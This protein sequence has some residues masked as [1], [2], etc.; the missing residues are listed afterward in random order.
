LQT[1]RSFLR[2]D[3][4]RWRDSARTGLRE[5]ASSAAVSR[6]RLGVDG[7]E[8]VGELKAKRRLRVGVVG[9]AGV[10]AWE[11]T[12]EVEREGETGVTSVWRIELKSW[13]A[14]SGELLGDSHG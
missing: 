8:P 1:E 12:G 6:R 10:G 13:L 4:R 3:S 11:R 14:C 7:A 9:W 5:Y 2:G